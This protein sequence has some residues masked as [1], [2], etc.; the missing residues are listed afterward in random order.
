MDQ[1]QKGAEVDDS[2]APQTYTLEWT[3]LQSNNVAVNA[4]IQK[5][6]TPSI[7]SKLLK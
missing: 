6:H 5:D 7:K 1:L 3:N 4:F 2:A